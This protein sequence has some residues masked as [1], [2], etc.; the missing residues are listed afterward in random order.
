MNA[1]RWCVVLVALA[2]IMLD[3]LGCI[4]MFEQPVFGF[5]TS[6]ADGVA[7]EHGDEARLNA[8][9]PGGPMD[10]A[11][12][13]LGDRVRIVRD[14]VDTYDRAVGQAAPMVRFVGANGRVVAVRRA[15]QNAS[16]SAI[17]LA[18]IGICLSALAIVLAVRGWH[19]AQARRLAIGMAWEAFEWIPNLNPIPP[20]AA[21]NDYVGVVFMGAGMVAL[22]AFATGW[23]AT[24]AAFARA[25]RWSAVA[26]AV[27]F[28]VA[29]AGANAFG[30]AGARV[31]V[32]GLVAWSICA[33]LIVAGLIVSVW[34]ARGVERRRI[35]WI[36]VTTALTFMPWIVFE[37]GTVL[38]GLQPQAPLW[39][40][41]PTVLL[42]IGYGYSILRRDIVDVGFALNRAAVFAATTALLVGLFG[43]LQWA[44]D[45]LLVQVVGRHDFLVQ[46]TI[47]VVVLY[48]VRAVRVRTDAFVTRVFFASRERRIAAIREL[49]AQVDAV[50]TPA[51]IAPFVVER[52]Q[53]LAGIAAAVYVEDGLGFARAAGTIGTERAAADAPSVVALRASLE[54]ARIEANNELGGAM[55]FPLAVRG[56]LRGGLACAYPAGDDEFAPDEAAALAALATRIAIARDDL[57]AQAL[58]AQ[59]A[60]LAAERDVLLDRLVA[61]ER[62]NALLER[63]AGEGARRSATSPLGVE[64]MDR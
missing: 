41:V 13:R 25:F 49:A 11:G 29:L 43:A 50:T 58:H 55:I 46:V 32:V 6:A 36:C 26:L 14:D 19:E 1:V 48:I 17:A 7:L 63:R 28:T 51:A 12:F 38:V 39:V 37:A 34:H 62:E 59:A 35:G 52:L 24:P 30:P 20:I 27:V 2:G 40:V 45:Q 44:A 53:A 18:A 5:S 60:R 21:I 9:V 57:L 31:F 56:R 16:A 64:Y 42:P 3:A 61:L 23:R 47:A 8:V 22:V 4:G 54:P 33:A 10:V 15:R